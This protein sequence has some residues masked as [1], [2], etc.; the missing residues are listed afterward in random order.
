MSHEFDRLCTSLTDFAWIW[1]IDVVKLICVLICNASGLN[2]LFNE[3][4]SREHH[5]GGDV[6]LNS[7]FSE[8]YR[9]R[10]YTEIKVKTGS[11]I[12]HW[13]TLFLHEH[14]LQGDKGPVAV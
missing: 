12:S 5:V 9:C 3:N 14:V 11:S 8:M 13:R 4:R 7:S 2:N 10:T 6:K 1:Q